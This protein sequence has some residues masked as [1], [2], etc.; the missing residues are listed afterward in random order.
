MFVDYLT[1]LPLAAWLLMLFAH[2]YTLNEHHTNFGEALNNFAR[3]AAV[4]AR[5]NSHRVAFFNVKG[6]HTKVIRL[7]ARGK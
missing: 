2:A 7:Q 1:F 4:V 6:V 3:L 5:K